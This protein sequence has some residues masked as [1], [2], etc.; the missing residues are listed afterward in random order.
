MDGILKNLI[1][2]VG[3]IW[4]NI[5]IA[6]KVSIIL[7]V[8]AAI[9]TMGVVIFMGTRPEWSVLYASLD[10]VTA[11]QVTDILRDEGIEYKLERSG[12][13]IRVPAKEINRI[14]LLV[15]SE[16]LPV[17]EDA[18]VKGYEHFDNAPLGMT[19]QQQKIMKL[20]AQQGELQKM[21]NAM[22]GVQNSRVMITI[23]EK[24]I[25][26]SQ[27]ERPSASVMVVMQRGIMLQPREIGSIRHL[28]ATSISGM[29]INDVT[30]ADNNGNTLAR[31]TKDDDVFSGDA[32]N[33]LA[34][35]RRMEDELKEKA[36]MALRRYVG[37][38]NVQAVVTLEVDFD[39]KL[40][41]V[42]NYDPKKQIILEEKV[43]SEKSQRATGQAGG[44]T[45]VEANLTV[46]VANPE[47]DVAG[48]RPESNED[49]QLQERRYANAS[50]TVET[51]SRG[52]RIT[53]LSVAVAVNSRP[54]N[55]DDPDAKV[56]PWPVGEF[57]RLVAVAVGADNYG[58]NGKVEVK[59][60]PFFVTPP[61]DDS[62]P[63]ADRVMT[64]IERLYDSPIARPFVAFVLLAL[65]FRLFRRYFNRNEQEEDVE[66]D[67][68]GE[69]VGEL[70]GMQTAQ[71][72]V[73]EESAIDQEELDE[74]GMMLEKLQEKASASPEMVASIMESWLTSE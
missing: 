71:L 27:S 48:N 12:T 32:N 70:E 33:Q 59:E 4:H 34:I 40:S 63:V 31:K 42:V 53:K 2:A 37:A 69:N 54:K 67:V 23:P 13:Q 29:Q 43:T 60:M 45:G 35:Q 19:E 52:A 11:S 24:R 8:L 57:N 41:R 6:Q 36:E 21:I 20:R 68:Y 16:G 74:V 64:N 9:G 58:E 25:F 10:K 72:D 44:K 61:I 1:G 49:K 3:E 28:V 62:V 50:E 22:P 55:P 38:E 46:N 66:S 18:A 39:D 17:D 47:E 14:R 5:G 65:L 15:A 7:M 56:D 73:G 51:K 30:I 26:R